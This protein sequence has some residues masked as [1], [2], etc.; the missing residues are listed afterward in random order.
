MIFKIRLSI[1]ISDTWPQSNTQVMVV[2]IW[3]MSCVVPGKINLKSFRESWYS[4][5][6]DH[7]AKLVPN[8]NKKL[9]TITEAGLWNNFDVVVLGS[10]G[11]KK[12]INIVFA[13][14]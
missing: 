11:I 14:L 9:A 8:L 4:D 2:T 12:S 10:R 3:T 1:D 7:V 13:A 6:N 5:I